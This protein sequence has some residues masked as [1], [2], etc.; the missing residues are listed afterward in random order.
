MLDMLIRPARRRRAR[1]II[2]GRRR[3]VRSTTATTLTSTVVRSAAGPFSSTG[4]SAVA[5]ASLTRR[6]IANPR[7]VP[8]ACPD[9]QPST[10][11]PRSPPPRAPDRSGSRASRRAVAGCAWSAGAR[12]T[13]ATRAECCADAAGGAGDQGTRMDAH[14]QSLSSCR[15]TDARPRRVLVPDVALGPAGR[16]PLPDPPRADPTLAPTAA[17]ASAYTAALAFLQALRS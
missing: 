17:R 8:R 2:P 4:P 7:P 12:C 10:D 9:P 5:P 15:A 13:R 6:S 11:P 1:S 16:H 3:A 14:V